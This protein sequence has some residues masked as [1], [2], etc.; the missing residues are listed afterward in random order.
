M[1]LEIFLRT[2]TYKSSVTIVFNQ[3][4]SIGDDITILRN[5]T[6]EDYTSVSGFFENSPSTFEDIQIGSTIEETVDNY[7]THVENWYTFFPNQTDVTPYTVEKTSSNTLIITSTDSFVELRAFNGLGS[8]AT[9]TFNNILSESAYAK[10][11]TKLDLYD[12]ETI[13]LNQR[14]KDYKDISKVFADF[15]K[16][17]KIP[18]S[19]TNN[20]SFGNF[21]NN[22][23]TDAFDAR[24][25]EECVIQ[26]DGVRFKEGFISLLG[27][28]MT[29]DYP[30]SYNISFTSANASL[31]TLLGDTKVSDLTYLD[32]FNHD[33]TFDNIRDKFFGG[34][35]ITYDT[36][37]NPVSLSNFGNE[38]HYYSS[39]LGQLG[40]LQGRPT[41]A[42]DMIY[43]FIS[44][45]SR[46]FYS[47][48]SSSGSFDS[49]NRNLKNGGSGLLTRGVNIFDLSP[50]I[51]AIHIIRG[52]EKQ[53]NIKF[54]DDSVFGS[55]IFNRNS[56][57]TDDSSSISFID[58]LSGKSPFMNAL[59]IHCNK[60]S[61]SSEEQTLSGSKLV[62][63][64]DLTSSGGTDLRDSEEDNKVRLFSTT[65][66]QTP[67][68]NEIKFFFS[69]ESGSTNGEYIV[70]VKQNGA[71]VFN[72]GVVSGDRDFEYSSKIGYKYGLFKK[73]RESYKDITIEVSSP[74]FMSGVQVKSVRV[75][76]FLK[77]K[78]FFGGESSIGQS[79][80]LYNDEASF[81]LNDQIDFRRDNAPTIKCIDFLK[82][83]FKMLNLVAYVDGDV[84]RVYH[85]NDY[86]RIGNPDIDESQRASRFDISKY[87]DSKSYSIDRSDIYSEVNFEFNKIKTVNGIKYE[88]LTGDNFGNE[89]YKSDIDSS[90]DGGKYDVKL[91]FDKMLYEQ[92]YDS[93][94]SSR[95]RVG[96]TWG[97]SV[98]ESFSPISVPNLLHFVKTGRMYGPSTFNRF[99][100]T[101]GLTR[102][103]LPSSTPSALV[104]SPKNFIEDDESTLQTTINLNFGD[105]GY[106]D[107]SINENSLFKVYYQD[108]IEQI[109]DNRTRLLKIDAYM[110]IS[111]FRNI[112]LN[113]TIIINGKSH[114]INSMKSNLNSDKT[115]FE[116]LTL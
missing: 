69:I 115:T 25:K 27:V 64:A 3:N 29:N 19:K 106:N 55:F 81:Q 57:L 116:L 89:N 65:A 104:W 95:E 2:D 30:S 93:N 68:R 92:L 36:E 71:E 53:F 67:I 56:Y 51:R 49:K 28:S 5:P 26:I 111:V 110:P 20:R 34:S 113:D 12:N 10:K 44:S 6:G 78:R 77:R 21:Y 37:E 35:Y 70:S 83:L 39:V 101:D 54:A 79:T 62:R 72:S 99:P 42:G 60:K 48:T 74:R 73:N 32:V 58:Y 87:I 4:M 22:E 109:F 33:L 94:P 40:G 52:I 102:Y 82:E 23:I 18:C 16:S 7:K 112:K 43:P 61:G 1:S 107:N 24:F 46:Y 8:K 100:V 85:Y 63:F 88:D 103:H 97:Y 75:E 84:I 50:S 11:Y 91:K 13:E 114:I 31:K 47:S 14:I 41:K 90:F 15:T 17:F 108:Q 105:E 86:M 66:A 98:N 76:L 96:L 45:E 38:D 80:S 59:Y 9:V